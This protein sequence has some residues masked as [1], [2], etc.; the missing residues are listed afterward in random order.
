MNS[1]RGKL[2]QPIE[3]SNTQPKQKRQGLRPSPSQTAKVKELATEGQLYN[4]EERE[5]DQKI[6]HRIQKCLSRANHST[7]PELE[8]KTAWRM[9]SRLMAQYDVTQA[10]LLANAEKQD[11][12]AVLGGQSTV[13]ITSTKDLSKRVI[14]QTWVHDV[15]N[16]MTIFFECGA[17]S[18]A[19]TASLKWTFYGIAANT[20]AAAMAFEMAHNLILE[21][22]RGKSK[23]TN[24]YCL[25]VG[26]GLKGIAREEKDEEKRQVKKKER[27]REESQ[28][29]IDI[30]KSQCGSGGP[31]GQNTPTKPGR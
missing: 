6:L 26:A 31:A 25:G 2:N 13:V 22:A 18:T 4:A 1:C 28:R 14:S 5:I 20:V 15:V 27:Q 17:Y 21:W 8:A 29:Q 24:S 3:M 30:S 7:T 19:L 9:S 10:D 11:D 16:A 23:D 12:Y